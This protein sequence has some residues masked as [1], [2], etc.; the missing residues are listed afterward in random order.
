MEGNK[1]LVDK[2]QKIGVG[3]MYL[4]WLSLLLVGALGYLLLGAD[5]W[6]ALIW[7]LAFLAIGLIFLPLAAKIFCRFFDWGYLFA[8][9]TGLALLTLSLWL[10]SSLKILPFYR[11]TVFALLIVSAGIIWYAFKGW[12]RFKE[13][14]QTENLVKIIIYEEALFLLGLVLLTYVRG[15]G[16]N[17]GVEKFMDLAFLNGLMR[18][19]FMPPVD[20]WFAGKPM[21]YYYYGQYVFAF[22]TKITGIRPGVAYSLG[23]ATM[24][25]FGFSLTFSLVANLIFLS[26]KRKVLPVV[27]A[28][29]ISASLL[30]MGYNLHTFVHST[31]LPLLKS[32]GLYQ[33]E[34]APYDWRDPRDF[35]GARPKTDDNLITEYPAYSYLLG[36]LHAQ[37]IDVFFVLAFLALLLAFTARSLEE[38]K[39]QKEPPPPSPWYKL[40]LE[41]VLMLFFLPVM[42]MTNA[43]DYPIYAVVLLVF[44]VGLNLVKNNFHDLTESIYQGLITGGK[45]IILSLLLLT[46]FLISF[47]NPTMGVHFTRLNHLLS[48][49]Y[50][51]QLFELW[52]F[53][54][55][56][57]ILFWRYLFK[58][59]PRYLE[60]QKRAVALKKPKTKVKSKVHAEA[61]QTTPSPTADS[62]AFGAKIRRIIMGL[63]AADLFVFLI[64]ICATGLFIGSE[65]VYQKD[66]SPPE[67]YR[68][69]TYWKVGLQL[70]ILL[71]IMV[72]YTAIRIF[73]IPRGRKKQVLL[74]VAV[75]IPILMAM[76]YPFW[77][78]SQAYGIGQ[79]GRYIGLD[80]SAYLKDLYPDD[81]QAAEWLNA[82]EKGQPVIVEAHGANQ[83]SYTQKGRFTSVTGLP[84][85]LGWYDHEWYWRGNQ[86]AAERDERANDVITLYEAEDMAAKR[87]ILEKYQVK[88]IIIGQLERES[89]QKLD[90]QKLISLGKVVFNSPGTKIIQVQ[91]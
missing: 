5:L 39:S 64:C 22:I 8:K 43:W 14:L 6:P 44:L 1:S 9:I 71:A 50:W 78:F 77:S 66:I 82:N 61:R 36:D 15:F 75:A 57:M 42:W 86:S 80:A 19:K 60:E 65:L 83:Q 85:I 49:V 16:P 27:L 47:V 90:E 81:H 53:Q 32:A 29:L 35:I 38:M 69:N 2:S 68:A 3:K 58:T 31:A 41:L 46:P 87:S 23:M 70:F 33:G 62:G 24:F 11:L 72:G 59:E 52:G 4:K 37:I 54:F 84:A 73:A 55:F 12:D 30:S 20:V 89:Y 26:G 74:A 51:F 7:W 34:V 25:S 28:G 76:M 17:N 67:H 18:T 45:A 40:P 88:Y 48:P 13:L 63:S 21:N 91:N 79:Y 10:L 56:F